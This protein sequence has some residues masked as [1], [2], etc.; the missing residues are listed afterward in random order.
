VL[1]VPR[2]GTYEFSIEQRGDTWLDLDGQPLIAHAGLQSRSLWSTAVSLVGGRRYDLSV[3]W[4]PAKG[5]PPPQLGLADVSP[6]IAA[7][8]NAARHASVAV[9]FA[10]AQQS[11][12]V[13]RPSL[14][15]PGDADA[16]ISAVAAANPKTVVVLNTGGA[17]LMPWINRAAA[18]LE[19]WYPGQGDGTATAAVLV[20]KVDPSGHLPVTF[21]AVSDASPVGTPAQFPGVDG[22]VSYEEGLDIG[23]R[24]YQAHNVKPLFPFGFGLSYTSFSLSHAAVHTRNHEIVADVTVTNE[25]PRAGTAVVQVYLQYP[26]AA[27]EPPEQLRAFDAVP[28]GNHQSSLIHFTLPATAFQAY[29]HGAFRTIPGTYSINI[30]QSSA[31]LPIHLTTNAP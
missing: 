26:K 8:V 6:E 9:V 11:E 3:T 30:G 22:T 17:V 12:D 28:L 16:L 19:A 15:L 25:G 10:S 24:W 31:S 4:L 2:S 18:V 1:K 20:G 13:D 23:Y 7:A 14:F 29:L 5:V 21:P 27:G